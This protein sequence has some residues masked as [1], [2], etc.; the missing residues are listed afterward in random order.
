MFCLSC[1]GVSSA[2]CIWAFLDPRCNFHRGDSCM[3]LF[4]LLSVCQVDW[5]AANTHSVH[6]MQEELVECPTIM[7]RELTVTR[8]HNTRDVSS[9]QL[10]G[11]VMRTLGV[12]PTNL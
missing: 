10:L 9:K 6:H 11:L 4:L 12:F 8:P 7:T 1:P 3:P 2:R 5:P